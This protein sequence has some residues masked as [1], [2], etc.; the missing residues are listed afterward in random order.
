VSPRLRLKRR[1]PRPH[2]VNTKHPRC[3]TPQYQRGQGGGVVSHEP[4]TSIYETRIGERM[5][6]ETPEGNV[7]ADIVPDQ[8]LIKWMEANPTGQGLGSKSLPIIENHLASMGHDKAWASP[9]DARSERFWKSQG[10]RWDL[11]PPQ[12]WRYMSK[13]LTPTRLVLSDRVHVSEL[14]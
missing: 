8:G 3:Q 13:S 10:Y 6:I 7:I 12:G 9:K 11:M 4:V 5:I 14:I 2:P 1:S